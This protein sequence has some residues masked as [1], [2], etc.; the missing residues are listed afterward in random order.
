MG[1][2]WGL[3]DVAEL[4]SGQPTLKSAPTAW[5]ST[6][7]EKCP[8]LLKA[9]ELGFPLLAVNHLNRLCRGWAEGKDELSQ[10]I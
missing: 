3:D 6:L 1:R 7:R 9:F 10:I 4:F 5:L 8:Y 2:T